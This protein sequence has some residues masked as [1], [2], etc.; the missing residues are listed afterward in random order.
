[1][2]THKCSMCGCS[3][4]NVELEMCATCQSL[5][6]ATIQPTPGIVQDATIAPVSETHVDESIKEFGDYELLE[7]IARVG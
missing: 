1:M 6:H 2:S 5:D 4:S 7:E 3:L